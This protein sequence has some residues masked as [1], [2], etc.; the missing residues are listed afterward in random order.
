MI[1]KLILAVVVAVAVGLVLV[2]LLGPVLTT[3][4]APVAV[5]V[6]DFFVAY[7]WVIGVLAG[8]WFFFAGSGWVSRFRGTPPVA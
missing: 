7:G 1:A 3:L 5:S 4:K 2:G 8:L 6:G